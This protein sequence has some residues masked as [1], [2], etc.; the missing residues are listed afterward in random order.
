M[1][2]GLPWKPPLMPFAEHSIELR[3]YLPASP[4]RDNEVFMVLEY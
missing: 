4:H 1:A 2:S 3:D